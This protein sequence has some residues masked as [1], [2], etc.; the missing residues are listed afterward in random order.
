MR[1]ILADD[2]AVT[3]RLFEAVIAEAGHDVAALENGDAAWQAFQATP[4]PLVILDWLM[5][6]MD[7][8]EVCRRIRASEWSRQTYVLMATGR[9]DPADVTSALDAGADDFITKPVAPEHLRAQL[10]I[11][12]RRIGDNEARWRAEDALARAQWL[13]GIG[14]TALTLQHEINNPLTA[15]LV[16]AELLA[17]ESDF[18]PAHRRRLEMIVQQAERIA[19]VVR[20][21]SS[22]DDPRTVEY[23]AGVTMLDLWSER[24]K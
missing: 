21:L 19:R 7:G 11:A 17:E 4:A 23:L 9:G 5:P 2:S 15:M 22:M 20:Q 1:V 14:Q 13:A 6:V 12:I 10:T 8:L 16:E 3:R 18:P 24:V